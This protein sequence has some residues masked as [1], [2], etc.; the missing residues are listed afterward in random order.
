M[1]PV[2]VVVGIALLAFAP[3]WRDF[4]PPARQWG[5][6]VGPFAH[7][8]D[9][10]LI[11]GVFLVVLIP[12]FFT[13]WRRLLTPEGRPLER[14]RRLAMVAVGA[15]RAGAG[16]LP[17]A[18]LNYLAL[19]GWAMPD[20]REEFSLDEFVERYALNLS[21]GGVFVRSRDPLPPGTPV[22]FET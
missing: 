18:M 20:E 2:L 21:R 14:R 5:R 17:E 9:F 6:E 3:F 22:A 13:V 19:M 16:F 12:F 10:L 8:G 11:F 7:P 4:T 15:Y 1:V